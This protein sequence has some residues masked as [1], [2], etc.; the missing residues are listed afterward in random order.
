FG[1]RRFPVATDTGALDAIALKTVLD[2]AL[3]VPR[4]ALSGQLTRHRFL[5]FAVLLKGLIA[6]QG[7]LFV[8]P[9]AQAR[10]LQ[11]DLAPSVDHVTGLVAMP[12]SWLLAPVA[13]FLLD[14]RCHD[15]D[16]K[17]TCLNSSHV[18]I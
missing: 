9:A 3:I 14:L 11:I 10:P 5:K 13:N 7:H 4:R 17:S 16:R 1:G 12:A 6:G 15:S 2:G 8:L 18:A